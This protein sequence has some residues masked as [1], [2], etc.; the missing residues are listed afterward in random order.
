MRHK[1]A[2]VMWNGDCNYFFSCGPFCALPAAA[3]LGQP[4]THAARQTVG[5]GVHAVGSAIGA[6]ICS[7]T[8]PTSHPPNLS[9]GR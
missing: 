3:V 5:A 7:S 1:R 6:L 4:W 8:C 2:H 9:A